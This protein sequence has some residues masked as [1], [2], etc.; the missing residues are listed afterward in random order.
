MGKISIE[1]QNAGADQPGW[2]AVYY[3]YLDQMNE[4][5][6]NKAPLSVNRQISLEESTANGKKLIPVTGTSV[7]K[8]GDKVMVRMTVKIDQDLDYVHLKD[9]RASCMEPIDVLSGYHWENGS[10]YYETVTDAAVHFYFSH[11]SKG[12]YVFTYPVYITQSG[13]F[14]GGLTTLECLYAPEFTAHSAGEILKV[15]LAN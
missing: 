12:T 2:G 7:L 4:V 3:Q 9:V 8:T 1:V 13:T 6:E 14:T 11:L 5:A 15:S 10:G